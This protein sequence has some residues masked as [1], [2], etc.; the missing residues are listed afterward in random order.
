MLIILF[1]YLVS[2]LLLDRIFL[3]FVHCNEVNSFVLMSS[4]GKPSESFAD[5]AK[6]RDHNNEILECFLFSFFRL[7]TVYQVCFSDGLDSSRKWSCIPDGVIHILRLQTFSKYL[8]PLYTENNE[9][10]GLYKKI[11]ER[12]CLTPPPPTGKIDQNIGPNGILYSKYRAFFP[13]SLNF[14]T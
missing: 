3:T 4:S 11:N 8:T 1:L 6:T 14:L 5:L 10:D 7:L 2:P 12:F 9:N 13:P